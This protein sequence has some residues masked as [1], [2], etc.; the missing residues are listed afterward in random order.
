MGTTMFVLESVFKLNGN[1]NDL[2]FG[3]ITEIGIVCGGVA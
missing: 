3:K 1:Y 2:D